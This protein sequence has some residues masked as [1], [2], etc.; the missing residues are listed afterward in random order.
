MKFLKIYIFT[1]LIIFFRVA[2]AYDEAAAKI[3]VV[4]VESILENSLAIGAIRKSINELSK[5]I[6]NE[7]NEQEK[8]YKKRQQE[9]LEVQKTVSQEKFDS[10]VLKFNKSVSKIQNNYSTKKNCIRACSFP[11]NRGSSSEN[12]LY[13]WRF[14]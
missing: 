14:S 9:L 11:G 12:Y 8:E 3:A 10:L 2:N 1:V 13:N 5:T 4:D 7:I 6:E